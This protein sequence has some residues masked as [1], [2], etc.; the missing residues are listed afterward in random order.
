MLTMQINCVMFAA[1][2]PS[3]RF[4]NCSVCSMYFH[5]QVHY[6]SLTFFS[7]EE[8]F[9]QFSSE[10]FCVFTSY[11]RQYVRLCSSNF[12]LIPA[13]AFGFCILVLSLFFIFL[14][15]RGNYSNLHHLMLSSWRPVNVGALWS[16]HSKLFVN[17]VAPSTAVLPKGEYK[18]TFLL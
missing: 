3:F 15:S 14:F 18:D 17:F 8:V 7:L 6:R 2:V 4:S 12:F 9:S 1:K 5:L 10:G 11:I 13:Q 16:P